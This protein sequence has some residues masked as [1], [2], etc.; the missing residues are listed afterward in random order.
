MTRSFGW[1]S[2]VAVMSAVTLA[3]GVASSA[4]S[5]KSPGSRTMP[6]KP[7]PGPALLKLSAR[8]VPEAQECGQASHVR[9]ALK[10]DT[11]KAETGRVFFTD[12]AGGLRV[13]PFSIPARS[14]QEVVVEGAVLDCSARLTQMVRVSRGEEAS[15]FLSAMLRPTSI[16]MVQ[17]FGMPASTETRHWLRRIAL[18]GTCGDASIVTSV[19][20][21]TSG[22]AG[23][24]VSVT[25]TIAGASQ[26]LEGT[27]TPGQP[28]TL[29]APLKIDCLNSGVPS[30]TFD[31][32]T[33][34]KASG[35]LRP[36][37]V[38]FE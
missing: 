1:F 34:M 20:A 29:T 7:L 3:A 27:T 36:S 37:S 25:L 5:D 19:Q 2:R 12:G 21:Q 30:V 35:T 22:P 32:T 14:A 28:L 6:S 15:P 24:K 26:V 4:P 23:E 8:V 11:L 18:S 31:L 10:N 17:G 38:T 9:V 13:K 16:A 33:G